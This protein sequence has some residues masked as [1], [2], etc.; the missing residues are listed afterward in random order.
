MRLLCTYQQVAVHGGTAVK[1]GAA[2]L[3]DLWPEGDQDAHRDSG[4]HDRGESGDEN[5]GVGLSICPPPPECR[6]DP[7]AGLDCDPTEEAHSAPHEALQESRAEVHGRPGSPAQWASPNTDS[8]QH[9][10]ETLEH[11]Q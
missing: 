9:P 10:R 6:T 2:T 5:D 8:P 7:S 3:V 11:E 1:K 4:E